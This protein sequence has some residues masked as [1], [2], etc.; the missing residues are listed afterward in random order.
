MSRRFKGQGTRYTWC[1]LFKFVI[2]INFDHLQVSFQPALSHVLTTSTT[3]A[4]CSHR[5][6]PQ[7]HVLLVYPGRYQA[8]TP[9]DYLFFRQIL[10]PL[11]GL[12]IPAPHCYIHHP[13][14]IPLAF[15]TPTTSYLPPPPISRLCGLI[16]SLSPA[17]AQ[18]PAPDIPS[19]PPPLI[20]HPIGPQSDPQQRP[21]HQTNTECITLS[22]RFDRANLPPLCDLPLLTSHH[23]HHLYLTP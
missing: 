21:S 18:S 8:T 22:F 1:Y 10:L 12:S 15:P 7:D 4:P 16:F 2:F 20:P 17:P 14:L 19:P 6:L 11:L 23:H 9:L 5:S 3:M 13:A